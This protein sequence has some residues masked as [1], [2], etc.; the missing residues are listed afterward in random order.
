M[1]T[2]GTQDERAEL[3]EHCRDRAYRADDLEWTA[4]LALVLAQLGRS[5]EAREAFEDAFG[6]LGRAEESIQLDVATNLVEAAAVL[7]D[8]FLGARLHYT[9]AWIPDRLVTIGE[10]WICKGSVERFR[11]LG[12]AAAGLFT[13]ADVHFA[14]AVARHRGLGA[15]PLLAQTLHQ[16]GTTLV[17]RDDPRAAECFQEA[18]AVAAQLR[19]TGLGLDGPG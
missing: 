8:A 16:W 7:R 18:D 3:A 10:G 15:R 6:R 11:A 17:G 12:E 9:L 19:L 1:V 14:K 13:E 5:D 2:W 4:A